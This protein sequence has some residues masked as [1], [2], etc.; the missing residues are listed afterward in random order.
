MTPVEQERVRACV[1]E[2]AEIFYRNT[3]SESLRTLEGIE[4]A[5]R[6]NILEK[7]SPEVGIFLSKKVQPPTEVN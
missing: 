2:L 7:V 3:P 5:V 1:Q 6:Q 4:Q